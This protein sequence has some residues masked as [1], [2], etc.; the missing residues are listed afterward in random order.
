MQDTLQDYP[1]DFVK[2]NNGMAML[3]GQVDYSDNGSGEVTLTFEENEGICNGGHT[4]FAMKTTGFELDENAVVHIEAIQIPDTVVGDERKEE[5]VG[6]ARAR[7]N[8]NRLER[9]SEANYLGYYDIFKDTLKKKIWCRGT[10]G[11]QMRT[12]M[13]L[14]LYIS[15]A[16]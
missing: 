5:I 8:N 15:S 4:Y 3:C 10:K 9:R 7:N 14:T 1:E 6:I 13:R 16:F 2:K 12:L 11:T